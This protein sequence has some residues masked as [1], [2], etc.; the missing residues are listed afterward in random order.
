MIKLSKMSQLIDRYLLYRLKVKKDPEAFA[1]I[2]DNYVSSIYRFAILKLPKQ[3]DAQDITAEVFTKLWQYLQQ[4]KPV[5]NIRAL[6]YKTCRNQIADFYRNSDKTI[7]LDSVT[8][9]AE[10]ASTLLDDV[11]RGKE[12]M[13]A[14][15]EVSL[16]LIQ[17]EKLKE[18]YRDVLALRLIDQLSFADIGIVLGK[19]PGHVRVIYH[20]GMKA[21]KAMKGFET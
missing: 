20:R 7:S 13:E 19:A 14:K 16:I 11:G 5:T 10:F 1:K 9:Q 18:D 21:L 3:E 6:L 15:S 17:L 12:I 2:Y 8:E 4:P